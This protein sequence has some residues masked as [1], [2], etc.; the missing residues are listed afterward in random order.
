VPSSVLDPPGAIRA[1]TVGA[2]PGMTPGVR[3]DPR[4]VVTV[5]GVAAAGMAAMPQP[6]QTGA[7]RY[8]ALQLAQSFR[9]ADTNLDGE[10]TRAEAQRLA[11]M[12]ASFEDI[13]RNKDGVLSRSE[14]EDGVR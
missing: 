11:I 2:V 7:G 14:Y 13:D 12:P 10:L 9:Q 5:P 3:P 4:A 8:T 1:G 6:A